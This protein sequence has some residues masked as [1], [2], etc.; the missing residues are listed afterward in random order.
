[1]AYPTRT[2]RDTWH[3]FVLSHDLRSGKK[4][5]LFFGRIAL[6]FVF[7]WSAVQ[8]VITQ[9]GGGM[10]TKGFLSGASVAGSPFAG[11]FNGLAGNWAVE[12]LVVYGE[13]LIG[14]SLLLGLA[15]RIG[16]VSGALQ[17]ALF[18]IAMWPIAD[19]P[20]AN[21]IID[22]RTF[23]LAVFVMMFFLTPGRFAGID[24]WIEKTRFVQRHPRL[25]AVL[26]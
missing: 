4:W 16:A 17:M 12:Y 5:S 2:I 6:G 10:A 22:V 9:L 18:T 14:I 20:T 3:E 21:P 15:T 13:L 8:K 7:L 11:F 1:M 25:K 24:G 23:Y 19:T 26:G